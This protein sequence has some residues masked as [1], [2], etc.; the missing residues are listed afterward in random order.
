MERRPEPGAIHAPGTLP[1]PGSQ[2]GT[3]WPS[4]DHPITSANHDM[5]GRGRFAKRVAAVINEV[6]HVEESSVLAIVGPWGS[7][8]RAVEGAIARGACTVEGARGPCSNASFWRF[9]HGWI[10]VQGIAD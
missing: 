3:H 9:R 1:A 4:P 6:R 10:R 7:G 8:R 5:L 2:P